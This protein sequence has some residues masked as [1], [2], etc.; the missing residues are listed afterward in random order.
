MTMQ[1]IILCILVLLTASLAEEWYEKNNLILIGPNNFSQLI[2][3][4]DPSYKIVTFFTRACSY[5]R[6]LKEV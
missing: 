6:I 3:Q 1:K 4:D 2:D 5:C